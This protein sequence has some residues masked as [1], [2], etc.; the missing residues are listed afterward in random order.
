MFTGIFSGI[1]CLRLG[2]FDCC[3]LVRLCLLAHGYFFCAWVILWFTCCLFWL[4]LDLT[5]VDGCLFTGCLVVAFSF[6]C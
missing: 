5:L 3:Y 1:V 2:L 4:V 6:D